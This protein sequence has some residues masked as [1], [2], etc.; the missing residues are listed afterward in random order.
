MVHIGRS[1]VS[2]LDDF[3]GLLITTCWPIP[4]PSTYAAIFGSLALAIAIMRRR[5]N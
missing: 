4:E 5:R 3:E 1:L 2:Q